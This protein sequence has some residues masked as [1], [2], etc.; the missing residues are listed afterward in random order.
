[1]LIEAYRATSGDF[2]WIDLVDPKIDELEYL[3][4]TYHLNITSVR[5]CLTPKHLPKVET[6]DNYIFVILRGYDES[7]HNSTIRALTR[8]IAFFIGKGFLITV[9]RND[10]AFMAQIRNNWIKNE[11][12]LLDE[13]LPRILIR[14]IQGIFS[15]YSQAIY[16]FERKVE[17]FEDKIFKNESNK[18]SI[19][20]KFMVKR[21]TSVIKQMLKMSLDLLPSLK[22][23][24]PQ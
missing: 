22:K 1:M 7:S 3:A 11:E 9:H 12:N 14:I 18:N 13:P 8:K 2:Q 16:H 23:Y 5:D 24:V 21:K 19:Q 6:I 17:E 15:S 20:Q 10:P 4:K